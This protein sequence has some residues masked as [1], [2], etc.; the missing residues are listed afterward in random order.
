MIKLGSTI[1]RSVYRATLA[2][3]SPENAH[4]AA[5]TTADTGRLI[6]GTALCCAFNKVNDPDVTLVQ[7]WL[8]TLEYIIQILTIILRIL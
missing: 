4:I 6:P 7:N 5:R 8:I 2:G 3:Q 1:C